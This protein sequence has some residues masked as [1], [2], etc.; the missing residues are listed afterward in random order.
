MERGA[1]RAFN[2]YINPVL[3]KPAIKKAAKFEI[4]EAVVKKALDRDEIKKQASMDVLAK[5]IKNRYKDLKPSGGGEESKETEAV[6]TDAGK[7]WA[8]KIDEKN[9]QAT[10]EMKEKAE[11][12]AKANKIISLMAKGTSKKRLANKS[13]EK[14]A[15]EQEKEKKN[16]EATNIQTVMR[17]RLAEKKVQE[18]RNAKIVGF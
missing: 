16:N 13:L 8:Q 14:A 5:R 10:Q 3:I 2:K 12:K 1:K 9:K 4:N 7:E 15:Q 18:K 11:T 17:Q 6:M